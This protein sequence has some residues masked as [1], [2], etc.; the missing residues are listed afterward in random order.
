M[1]LLHPFKVDN[2]G[3]SYFKTERRPHGFLAPNLNPKTGERFKGEKR[4][5]YEGG[6]RIPFIVRWPGMIAPGTRSDYLGYFPDVMPTLAELAGVEPAEKTDGISFVP[7][8]L[9]AEQAGRKQE[10]HQYLYWEDP[11]SYAVRMG[12]WKLIQLSG[13]PLELYDLSTDL[14]ELN[15]VASEHPEILEKMKKYAKEAHTPPREGQVLDASI[16]FQGHDKD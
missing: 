13:E 5:F 6:L 15:N 1:D 3:E 2:G 9:G 11:Y 4:S 14:E 12:D 16:G 7:T 8:L 10:Q